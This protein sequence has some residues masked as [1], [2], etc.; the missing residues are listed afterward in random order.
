MTIAGPAYMNGGTEQHTVC[1]AKFL[2]PRRV[3]LTQVLITNP[4]MID[5]EATPPHCCAVHYCHPDHLETRTQS[6]DCLISWGIDLDKWLIPNGRRQVINV[7]HGASD[8]QQRILE[9]SRTTHN[10]IVCV[11]KHAA[12][13]LHFTTPHTIITNGIDTS[14]LTETMTREEARELYGFED[15]IHV[16]GFLGRL[17]EDKHVDRIIRALPLMPN[18]VS[19]LIIG[20]G[21][22]REELQQLADT[23]AP[24]RVVFDSIDTYLGDAFQCMDS[25]VMPSEHEGFCLAAAEAMWSGVP[26]VMTPVGLAAEDLRNGSTAILIDGSTQSI[27]DAVYQLARHPSAAR[28]MANRA[29]NI[30]RTQYQ[31]RRMAAEYTALIEALCEARQ[32]CG[33]PDEVPY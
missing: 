18:H 25:F 29:R 15:H 2:D 32:P 31:A 17:A 26:L 5:R 20:T 30:A 16:T 10:H 3:E 12:D 22:M 7:A 9:E 13:R 14:R 11:S 27:A 23:I 33:C 4:D 19:A 1:L 8:W 24:G 6:T 28:V 21:H